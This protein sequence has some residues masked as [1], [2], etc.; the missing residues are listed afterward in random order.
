MKKYKFLF[1]A[2]PVSQVVADIRYFDSTK[3]II[4]SVLFIVSNFLMSLL[5]CDALFK[6][7]KKESQ[8]IELAYT[9][10][11]TVLDQGI[12]VVLEL[13]DWN[14]NIIGEL[15]QIKQTHNNS[16]VA[17]LNHFGVVFDIRI[18]IA[19]KIVL[20]V[21]FLTLLLK[22]KN[23]FLGVGLQLLTSAQLS[24]V[25]DS[26]FRGYVL[27]SFYYYR[28][29]C[30]DLKDYY[31]DAGIIVVAIYIILKLDNKKQKKED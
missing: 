15:F 28:L 30:Y 9:V 27:D 4:S 14:C 1:L 29:V 20:L 12:K 26:S 10:L 6:L 18:V 24:S 31:V 3:Q 23:K 7:T 16:Q 17:V 22:N 5:L 19:L 8:Y 2:I 13:T 11:L 25:I 21:I